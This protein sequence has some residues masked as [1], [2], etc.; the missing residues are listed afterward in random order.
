MTRVWRNWGRTVTAR[1]AAVARPES[2]DEVAAL[3]RFARGEGRTLK[4]VGAGHSFTAIAAADDL[5]IDLGA[6]SGIRGIR[7]SRITFGAGTRLYDVAPLLRPHGLALENM[8]DI[9][10]QTVAGATSTG[11]HGT[12]ARFGG[13]ATRIVGAE[14]ITGE[15][16]PLTV[17]DTENAELLPA[18]QLGLGGLGILTTLT[19]DCV[20]AFLLHAVERPMGFDEVLDDVDAQM[21]ATDHV[22]FYWWP[23]TER[24]MMKANTR[25]PGGAE[26]R[27]VGAVADWVEERL[28]SNGV[29]AA[30]CAVGHAIPALTP[31]INRLA[32]RVYGDRE[33]VDHSHEVF[34]APR[35][36]RFREMEYALPREAVP[37]ALRELRRAIDEA[38][39]RIE[40]PVEVRVA[41]AD[42]TWLST[43]YGRDSGYIAVHRSVREDPTAYF[44]AAERIFL[45][46]DG[47]PHWGKMHSL[48]R[49][50]LEARYPRFGDFLAVRDRLDPER[51]FTNP[52]LA[53]VLDGERVE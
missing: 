36:V 14:L 12:G 31:A 37:S 50:E 34:T 4:A 47:R 9:D 27:P 16:R 10:R 21:S 6:L 5:Q 46:H 43:A 8:G 23:H 44:A 20:D 41:A 48:G 38:G 33:Y 3:V 15:G 32:T 11:T 52:Y 25:L 2:V 45:A 40:F 18:V 53:R 28:L 51:M 7:G 42:D 24:V 26:R 35:D 49:A 22:E 19:I 1:P 17:S 13:L 29:L 30:K 39:W